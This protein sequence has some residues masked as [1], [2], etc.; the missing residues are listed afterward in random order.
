MIMYV[1]PGQ[2]SQKI[3]MGSDLFDKYPELCE[4]AD[5]VLGYSVK[6]LCLEDSVRLNNTEYTQPALFV[7]NALNYHERLNNTN[8]SPSFVAGHSLGEYSALYAAGVF[9]FETGLKLVKKRGELM[10]RCEGGGMAAVLGLK[11]ED[12]RSVI[13]DNNLDDVYIANLNTEKQIVLSGKKDK[14]YNAKSY[15]ENNGASAYIPLNV[16]GAFHSPLMEEA[17]KEFSEYINQFQFLEMQIPIISNVYAKPYDISEIKETM[18]EQMTSSVRWTESIQYV[19]D[20]QVTEIVQIGP[21]NVVDGLIRKIKRE[22]TVKPVLNIEDNIVETK[23][24]NEVENINTQIHK[25]SNKENKTNKNVA[26]NLGSQDFM[27]TFGLKYPYVIGG[28]YKGVSSADMVIRASKGGLLGFFGTG[29]VSI[30]NI[31]ENLKK[32]QQNLSSNEPYGVNFL[33]HLDERIEEQLINLLLNYDIKVIEASAFIS[34]TPALALYKIKGLKKQ[35]E[36]IISTHH[37]IGKISRPEVAE[38]FLSPIRENIIEKLLHD[39]KI[40]SEEASMAK[41]VPVADAICAEADS[42]GHTDY[43]VA[44][45]L[46]PTMI[47]IR[48]R[49]KEAYNYS[50]DI[51]VGTG[52]GI[53]TPEA[54]AAAFLLGADFIVTGSINQCTVEAGTSDSVKTLLQKM[55]I[56]DTDYAPAGDMFELGAKVQVLKRGL[57]FPSRANKLYEL[58]RHYNSIEELDERTKHQLETKYF[59]KTFEEIYEDVKNYYDEDEVNKAEDNEKHKMK[60]IFKWYLGNGT[61]LALN[62]EQDRVVD[63]QVFCGPALGA[64]NQWVKGTQLENWE[65][66][67]VDEIGIKLMD[68]ARLYMNNFINK[69]N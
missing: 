47:R 28:M 13:S 8:E 24:V 11:E 68:E 67:H 66:R 6:K 69:L 44:Y 26:Y 63:Y 40:T 34:I 62:G 22:Y 41:N 21:G 46:L 25:D 55:N 48:N 2:G 57:F 17:K 33:H 37:V 54:A 61:R 5:K 31:E 51:K 30:N 14:I 60:L 20:R 12:I 42:G 32:I 29:G 3:G 50:Y 1:F 35:G 39:G 45:T 4:K 18:V 58:Y 59:R 36:Q 56:Q 27:K 10:G 7:V 64:F 38:A 16:S 43:S 15:F 23:P 65:N 9:D 52:G 53:G 49:M 19:L